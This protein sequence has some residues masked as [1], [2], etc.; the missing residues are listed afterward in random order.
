MI[1][2][3]RNNNKVVQENPVLP[4]KDFYPVEKLKEL[5]KEVIITLKEETQEK[6]KSKKRRTKKDV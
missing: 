5:P 3:N 6:P 2:F 1:T 4:T